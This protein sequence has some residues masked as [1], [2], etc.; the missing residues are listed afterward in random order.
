[1]FVDIHNSRRLPVDPISYTEPTQRE[2][3]DNSAGSAAATR[4][5]FRIGVVAIDVHHVTNL[6]DNQLGLLA[7][8]LQI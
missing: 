3:V 5:L 8:A 2:F 1:L 6:L 4:V 7:D